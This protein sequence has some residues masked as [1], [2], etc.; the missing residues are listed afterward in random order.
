MKRPDWR[1]VREIVLWGLVAAWGVIS[2]LLHA[3]GALFAVAAGVLVGVLWALRQAILSLGDVGEF[4]SSALGPCVAF[5]IGIWG[6]GF[7]I[8]LPAA[9]AFGISVPLAI[10]YS[11]QLI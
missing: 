7:G 3:N 9:A 11:W 8:G 1:S 5:G 2:L 6:G 4:I 10:R